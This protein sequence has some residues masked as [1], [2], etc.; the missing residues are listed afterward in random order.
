MLAGTSYLDVSWPYG[1]GFS[2]VYSILFDALTDMDNIL[3]PLKFPQPTEECRKEANKFMVNRRSPLRRIVTALEFRWNR[4]R[5]TQ[6]CKSDVEG[7]RKYYNRK[8]FF[9]LCVQAAVT[10]DYKLVFFLQDTI[11]VLM[12]LLRYQLNTLLTSGLLPY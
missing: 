5:I 11:V 1:I 12:T 8:K 7:P 6:P 10:T 4:N 9:A 3:Q 2:T